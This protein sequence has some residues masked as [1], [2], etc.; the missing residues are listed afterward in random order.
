NVLI[1][2]W[3]LKAF[4]AE[5]SS[6]AERPLEADLRLENGMIVGTVTN[7]LDVPLQDVAL[8]RGNATQHIGFVAARGSAEVR[9]PLSSQ[10]FDNSSPAKLLPPPAGVSAPQTGY[11][12]PYSGRDSNAEQR[13][14]NR[15]IEL[16]SA[17]LYPYIGALPPLDM[18]VT[19]LAWGP[20][21]PDPIG[22]ERYS[23]QLEEATLWVSQATVRP[24]GQGD[25]SVK[26]GTVPYTVYTP[27]DS[28]EWRARGAGAGAAVQLAP[29]QAFPQPTPPSG[30]TAYA[31]E[32]LLLK[33]YAE[34]RYSLPPG[35]VARTLRLDFRSAAASPDPIRV[36]AFNTNTG[37]WDDAGRVTADST[38]PLDIPDPAPY[39]GPAGD[40][41]LRLVAGQPGVTLVRPVL[42]IAVNVEGQQ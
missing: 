31:A 22:V 25:P 26:S 17:G 7:R 33:P 39:V 38:A 18:R 11:S 40:V 16:L 29:G 32:T 34:V 19:L 12:Y 9:L 14:Y 27:G 1:N 5:H 36:L 20:P 3:S 4:M 8:V 13:T 24:G 10:V 15:K 21:P 6:Q 35:T 41:T 42:D 23:S 2:T 37:E 30:S 28:I